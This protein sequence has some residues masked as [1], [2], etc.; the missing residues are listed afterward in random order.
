LSILALTLDFV[1]SPSRFFAV[2]EAEEAFVAAG[3]FPFP[4]A[5]G[6]LRL[7]LGRSE[8]GTR[9][10]G[11]GEWR[12]EEEGRYGKVWGKFTKAGHSHIYSSCAAFRTARSTTEDTRGLNPW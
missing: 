3:F 1:Q 7:E 2:L 5:M 4:I 9:L 8:N 12:E 10:R 6:E 11:R